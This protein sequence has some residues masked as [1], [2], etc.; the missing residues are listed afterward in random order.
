MTRKQFIRLLVL[1]S[2]LFRGQF[3]SADPPAQPKSGWVGK[4][5]M[6]REGVKYRMGQRDLSQ[7]LDLPLEVFAED[8]EWLIVSGGKVRK[9][10]V[11]PLEEAP[12]YYDKMLRMNPRNSWALCQ[13]GILLYC[14][15]Q[16]TDALEQVDLALKHDGKNVEALVM[17]GLIIAQNNEFELA[18][19]QFDRAI[20]IRPDYADAYMQRAQMRFEELDEIEPAIADYTAAIKA[21]PEFSE[22]YVGRGAIH[23]NQGR[24]KSALDDY[25]RTLELDPYADDALANRALLRAACTDASLRDGKLAIADAQR[26]CEL[27]HHED[28]ENL[29][30]LA[31]AYAENGQFDQAIQWQQK[32]LSK[33]R[34]RPNSDWRERLELYQAKKPYRYDGEQ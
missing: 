22:A 16:F 21:C 24:M 28:L 17:R 13:K 5:A 29:A 3:V 10:D 20:Q 4:C 14:D 32:A 31:A 6:P 25:N 8:G 12:A 1:C 18:I 26:A 27:T 23:H 11:I 7:A 33:W 15:N 30:T 9:V 19:Q 2:T 34:G